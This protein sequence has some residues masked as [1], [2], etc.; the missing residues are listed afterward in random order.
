M[1]F[2]MVCASHTPLLMKEQFASASICD[3][4]AHSFR[5]M[6]GFIEEF[7]P[8]Q[9]IQ[10][11]PDHYHGF[12]Y[13]NMP[14]FC[15]GTA[16]RSYGDWGTRAGPLN[17]DESFALDILDGVRQADIDLSVSY[18]MV[19]DHGFVQMWET[20]WGDFTRY[21]IV[22]IFV[23]AIS[24]PLPTY[25]RARM[26][27]E[28]VGR[29][30]ATSGKR[31]LFAASGGLSHDPVVPK[32]QGAS[33]ELRNRLLGRAHF[34]PEQQA[35]REQQVEEAA[36][37]AMLGKGPARPLN[38]EWDRAF[39]DTLTKGDRT[40]IDGFTAEGVDAVAGAGGNEVLCWVA[41]AAALSTAGPYHVVQHDY[42]DIP[43]WI[44]G[45]GHISALS[46]VE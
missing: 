13:D 19:V 7:Q 4:V 5:R 21:R 8:D 32:M 43:G 29:R 42:M 14:P 25:R 28:S 36:R 44:A 2:A 20:M 10:F 24:P 22:P 45:L 40:A 11:S 30:A 18:D 33:P 15:I 1:Q 23:N 27:G 46:K 41:A 3:Q 12:H 17:V 16:A 31:I 26:L 39:M 34:G 37:A 6:A 35:R 38:P 9:I